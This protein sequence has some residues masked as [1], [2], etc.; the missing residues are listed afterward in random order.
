V[1]RFDSICTVFGRGLAL[2]DGALRPSLGLTA[3]GECHAVGCAT[4]RL[5]R[6]EA[7]TTDI[8]PPRRETRE[9]FKNQNEGRSNSTSI[10]RELLLAASWSHCCSGTVLAGAEIANHVKISLS[11]SPPVLAGASWNQMIRSSIFPCFCFEPSPRRRKWSFNPLWLLDRCQRW[12]LILFLCPLW[13]YPPCKLSFLTPPLA[14]SHINTQRK[15]DFNEW[16]WNILNTHIRGFSLCTT[17]SWPRWCLLAWVL[18]WGS[19]DPCF[20]LDFQFG[21][22]A[23]FDAKCQETWYLVI[24]PFRLQARLTLLYSSTRLCTITSLLWF[25]SLCASSCS[26]WVGK[27]SLKS[28]CLVA[29]RKSW[30]SQGHG[31]NLEPEIH[32]AHAMFLFAVGESGCTGPKISLSIQLLSKNIVWVGVYPCQSLEF[33]SCFVHVFVLD[34]HFSHWCPSNCFLEVEYVRRN[35]DTLFHR[36]QLIVPGPMPEKQAHTRIIITNK[37]IIIGDREAEV[38]SI[39]KHVWKQ[40]APTSTKIPSGRRDACFGWFGLI[41]LV[42]KSSTGVRC[43]RSSLLDASEWPMYFHFHECSCVQFLLR[44]APFDQVTFIVPRGERNW[45]AFKNAFY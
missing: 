15:N 4:Q 40:A 1:K 36:L 32:A 27:N 10:S 5:A 31:Q 6:P 18:P 16:Y 29:F 3:L 22:F 30:R 25:L 8:W 39:Q 44:N 43:R 2:R 21:Y 17:R 33:R 12:S 45:A 26:L 38:K 28:P 13:L 19:G 42:P 35:W 7:D 24:G 23:Y 34:K 41:C 20:E 9:R 11:H 14:S 37:Y